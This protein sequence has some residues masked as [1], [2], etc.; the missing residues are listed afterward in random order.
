VPTPALSG[1]LRPYQERGLSWLHFLARLGL[2]G[3]LADDMGLGKTAQTLSLLLAERSDPGPVR[4][5][6]ADLPDV[7]G[8]QLAE[9]GGPVRARP[10][11]YVHHGGTRKRDDE[12]RSAVASSDVVITTYG[13]GL[14]G[15]G[16]ASR[17]PMG[18][19]RVRRGAGHQETAAPA[20]P[21]RAGDSART[22]VCVTGTPGE[23]TSPSS[24]SIHGVL[25]TRGCWDG[26]A[27]RRRFQEPI[28]V[29]GDPMPRCAEACH[30]PFSLRPAENRQ[31][32]HLGSAGEERDEG[33][34]HAH[35]R[36]GTL[37]QRWSRT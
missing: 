3:I 9:G 36:A 21:G 12:F 28:E 32:D 26:E 18:T 19:D 37:Y 30:R 11:V 17:C 23:N 1:T 27:F 14:R 35:R 5:D 10:A 33:V 24:A 6:S 13:N 2:G 20:G 31:V 8:Q 15:P 22:R 25:E 4:A 29:R 7:A 16:G 34:V